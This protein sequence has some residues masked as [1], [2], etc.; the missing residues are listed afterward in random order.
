MTKSTEKSAKIAY[1]DKSGNP[2]MLIQSRDYSGVNLSKCALDGTMLGDMIFTGAN[3]T[4][5]SLQR[6]DFEAAILMGCNLYDAD[7]S[8]SVLIDADLSGANLFG[9]T[10][11]DAKLTQANFTGATMPDGTMYEKGYKFKLK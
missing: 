3:F 2:A 7:M 8:E 5:T 1:I 4:P 10:F 11:G 9:A 6:C